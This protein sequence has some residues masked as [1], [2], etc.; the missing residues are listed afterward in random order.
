MRTALVLIALIAAPG[1]ADEGLAFI[2]IVHPENAIM[3]ADKKFIADGFL[4]K[5]TR[6]SNDSV[7]KPID[8]KKTANV[9][10][11]FSRRVL[12][13]S[14]S[15]VRTYWNQIVFSGRGVPPP[16]VDSDA[17]V[18]KFVATNPGAIGYVTTSSKLEGV[19]VIQVK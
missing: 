4:K 1:R 6:W 3:H 14:V 8:Q 5:R 19:K 10:A 12:D 9:R 7:M 15:S 2:V 18:I 13:R 16:E 11:V 17:A